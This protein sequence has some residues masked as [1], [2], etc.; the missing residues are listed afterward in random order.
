MLR[1]LLRIW[2]LTRPIETLIV[3][4]EPQTMIDMALSFQEADG[5]AQIWFVVL[6]R[7]C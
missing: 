2:L 5:C 7:L 6:I 3:W 1:P 4:T